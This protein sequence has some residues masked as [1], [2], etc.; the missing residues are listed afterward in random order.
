MREDMDVSDAHVPS[1]ENGALVLVV[2][3]LTEIADGVFGISTVLCRSELQAVASATVPSS[4]SI[5]TVL[6]TMVFVVRL[7]FRNRSHISGAF[8]LPKPRFS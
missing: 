1:S 4:V 6:F 8:G 5:E 3:V 2:D 7:Q